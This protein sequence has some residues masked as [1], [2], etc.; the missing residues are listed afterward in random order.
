MVF[1]ATFNNISAI[2]WQSVLLVEDTRVRHQPVASVKM[3]LL[4]PCTLMEEEEVVDKLHHIMLYRVHL[5]WACF[6]LTTLVLINTDCKGSCKS[7]YNTITTSTAPQR[8]HDNN[9]IVYIMCYKILPMLTFRFF[10]HKRFSYR[11]VSMLGSNVVDCGFDPR[12]GQTKDYE[13]SICY[14]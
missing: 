12:A 6:E 7:N 8:L 9:C 3:M 10:R 14:F 1:N 11:I 5:V 4:Q 13:I 2:S